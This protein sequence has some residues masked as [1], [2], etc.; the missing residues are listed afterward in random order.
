M[1]GGGWGFRGAVRGCTGRGEVRAGCPTEEQPRK[2]RGGR[3]PDPGRPQTLGATGQKAAWT[4][5]VFALG[6]RLEAPQQPAAL[7]QKAPG[8]ALGPGCEARGQV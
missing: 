3:A 6:G 1:A 8:G 7:E 4:G 2:G 5:G